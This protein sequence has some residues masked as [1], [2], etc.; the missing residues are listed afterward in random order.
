MTAF[1]NIYMQMN[2]V[3]ILQENFGVGWLAGVVNGV[4]INVFNALYGWLAK[5]LTEW[6]NHRTQTEYLY[7]T[8]RMHR[9]LKTMHD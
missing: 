1:V 8:R 5:A 7:D 6:E 9:P 2:A 4:V 3:R